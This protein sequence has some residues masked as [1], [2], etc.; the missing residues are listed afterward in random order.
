MRSALPAIL[1]FAGGTVSLSSLTLPGL[2]LG[3][4]L[5]AV[6]DVLVVASFSRRV[7]EYSDETEPTQQ[8]TAT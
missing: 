7:V 8:A 2:V 1:A 6:G 3:L 4:A 5:L